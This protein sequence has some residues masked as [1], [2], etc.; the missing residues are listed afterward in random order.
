MEILKAT[1]QGILSIGGKEIKCAVLNDST[2]VLT[3]ESLFETFERKKY[4]KP[5]ERKSEVAQPILYTNK[6]GKKIRGFKALILPEICN[7]FIKA[8][9]D[10]ALRKNQLDLASQSMNMLSGFAKLGITALID[11]ATGHRENLKE[12]EYQKLIKM[13]LAPEFR[14]D[15]RFPKELFERVCQLRGWRYE[16]DTTKYTPEMGDFINKYIYSVSLKR[17]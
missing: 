8:Y 5:D 4:T 12:D 16:S 13:F 9:Q 15:K 17:L 6:R 10:G 3:S 14:N 11:E 2:R 1:H 7:V